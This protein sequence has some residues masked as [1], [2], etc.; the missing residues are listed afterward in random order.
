MLGAPDVLSQA[1]ALEL[2]PALER[3]LEQHTAAGRRVVAFGE[4]AAR[5]PRGPRPQPPP[6]LEPRALVAL[7][8]QLRPD[9]A[10]TIEFLRR[11]R[12]DLKL[13]SG[14]ARQTVTAVAHGV[15]V[16]RTPA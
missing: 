15:G 1:G 14:D 5:A 3:S 12:V 2:P 8:E 7:E 16:P 4:T 11:Q 9:A 10:E 6:K 13:I